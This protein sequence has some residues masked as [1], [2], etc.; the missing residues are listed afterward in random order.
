M[1]RPDNIVTISDFSASL[2][3]IL[4]IYPF[5]TVNK[6]KEQPFGYSSS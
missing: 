2:F 4:G 5:Y 6:K 1:P 3:T